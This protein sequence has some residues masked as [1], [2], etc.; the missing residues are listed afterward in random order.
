M[1]LLFHNLASLHN[2]ISIDDSWD[3]ADAFTD[4]AAGDNLFFQQFG[5]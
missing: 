3:F 5:G 1:D 2:I 4:P